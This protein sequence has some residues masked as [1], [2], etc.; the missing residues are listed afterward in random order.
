MKWSELK[1]NK[2]KK[3]NKNYPKIL[4][5]LKKPPKQLFYRGSLDK[6]L[7]NKAIGIVGSRRMTRYGASVVD[8]FVAHFASLGITTVSG[9]MYGVDTLV[10]AKTIEYGGQTIAV[11][12]GGINQPYPPENDNLYTDIVQS[13][14]LVLSEYKPEM[15]PQ[16][17]TYP[18]RNRIIAALSTLGVLVIEASEKSGSLITAR[19]AL[20]LNKKVYAIPG[21]ITSSVSSGTNEWIKNG[22]ATMVTSPEDI[23][24]TKKVKNDTVSNTF[25]TLE[26][27]IIKALE[28]EDLSIDELSVALNED[29]VTLSS[30]LTTLSLSGVVTEAAGRYFIS[31]S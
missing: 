19:I 15:K 4:N 29:I 30:T 8:K 28:A 20:K 14:G 1:V 7:F 5:K 3:E 18:E 2:L 6:Q 16:L 13:G 12:G 26:N 25:D 31:R 23:I 22:K 27:K 24:K 17:W 11:M 10:H 21:P 9:Y